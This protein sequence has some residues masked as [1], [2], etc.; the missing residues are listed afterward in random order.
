LHDNYLQDNRRSTALTSLRVFRLYKTTNGK[1][2]KLWPTDYI[3]N[4]VRFFSHR[5]HC[6]DQI[7]QVWL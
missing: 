5:R 1:N 2:K 3:G 4:N 6:D 7:V